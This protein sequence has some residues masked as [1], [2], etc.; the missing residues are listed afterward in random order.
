MSSKKMRNQKKQSANPA[1]WSGKTRRMVLYS[2]VPVIPDEFDTVVKTCGH[3]R[4]SAVTASISQNLVTNTLLQ[5][6]GT[7]WSMVGQATSVANI[8]KNYS[9]YRVMKYALRVRAIPNTTSA[10]WTAILH[11][12]EDPAFASGSSFSP[13]SGSYPNAQIKMIPSTANTPNIVPFNKI[14]TITDVVGSD[15]AQTDEDFAG[16]VSTAGVFSDPARLTYAIFYQGLISGSAFG[17][18]T[19]PTFEVELLQWVKF[20]ERRV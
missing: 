10:C 14:M 3:I 12:P 2:S 1:A 7:P 6:A 16:A 8:A 5:S 11:V 17:A 19:S 15:S 18:S 4:S 13:V 20:Y 9:F